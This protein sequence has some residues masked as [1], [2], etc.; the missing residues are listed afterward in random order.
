MQGLGIPFYLLFKPYDELDADFTLIGNN[1]KIFIAYL[2]EQE[3]CLN[4]VRVRYKNPVSVN[5]NKV[6]KVTLKNFILY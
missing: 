2:E 3:D 4:S 1:S 6:S 5:I